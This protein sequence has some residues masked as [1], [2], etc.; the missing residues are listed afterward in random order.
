MVAI[1]AI[2]A[3]VAWAIVSMTRRTD[4]GIRQDTPRDDTLTTLQRR[5]ASGEIDEQE[6]TRRRDVLA[7]R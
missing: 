5:F 2:I 6:Y 1:V 4:A 7:N 3:L